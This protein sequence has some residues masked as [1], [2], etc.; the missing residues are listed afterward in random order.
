[1]GAW[2]NHEQHIISCLL[3]KFDIASALSMLVETF[4][5]NHC[6]A[7]VRLRFQHGPRW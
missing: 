5:F 3:L 6:S 4:H 7:R 2:V 1:M